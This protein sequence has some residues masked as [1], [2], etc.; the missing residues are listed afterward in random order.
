MGQVK[1]FSNRCSRIPAQMNRN[2]THHMTQQW[3]PKLY[4]S[5]VS[6]L[7]WSKSCDSR[8]SHVTPVLSIMSSLSH[9]QNC[10]FLTHHT[11]SLSLIYLLSHSHSSQKLSPQQGMM[12]ASFTSSLHLWQMSSGGISIF[13]GVLAT[14]ALLLF[15]WD[16]CTALL[17]E[18]EHRL[19]LDLQP[20]FQ[21]TTQMFTNTRLLRW[22]RAWS[23]TEHKVAILQNYWEYRHDLIGWYLLVAN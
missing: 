11:G 16:P 1:S 12:T 18:R 13:W 22:R 20:L 10:L 6:L 5:R 7:L 4:H 21:T 15:T 14:S 23:T 9:S 2:V 19:T 8:A 17:A 3:V